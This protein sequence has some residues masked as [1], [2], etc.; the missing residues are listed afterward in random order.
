M[1]QLY[2]DSGQHVGALVACKDQH[3]KHALACDEKTLYFSYPV[4]GPYL[5]EIKVEAYV[6]TKSDEFVIKEVGGASDDG[7]V[8][9]T[10]A[11]NTEGIENCVFAGGFEAVEKTV[12]EVL[13]QALEDSEWSVGTSQ[14]TKKRTIRK[15]DDCNA[16]D[17]LEQCVSTYRAEVELDTLNK[18]I[19]IFEARGQNRGVFFMEGVN[20]QRLEYVRDSYDFFTE[21][22]PIGKDGL[23]LLSDPDD[24]VLILTNYTY[25]HKRVKRIWRDERYTNVNTLREDA[26]A[27][28]AEACQP[29]SSYSTTVK[30]LSKS[31]VEHPDFFAYEVGDT[32]TLISK[33]T[34][35]K[36]QQRIV[37]VDEY[38]DNTDNT[39]ELNTAAKSFAQMQ[40]DEAEAAAETA[41]RLSN[42]YTDD[43][44]GDYTTAE[45]AEEIA[46]AAA[47][48]ID[49]SGYATKDQL[50][51]AMNY[52]YNVA[53]EA[54][55]AAETAAQEYAAT[56]EANAKSAFQEALKAYYTAEMTDTTIQE[57]IDGHEAQEA[58]AYATKAE[59]ATVSAAAEMAQETADAANNKVIGTAETNAAGVALVALPEEFAAVAAGSFRIW[60][61]AHGAA[62]L[63]V[64]EYSTN[65]FTVEGAQITTF[66]WMAVR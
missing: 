34:G 42:A 14:I 65:S 59:V 40:K 36:E 45:E 21:I 3:V 5:H 50:T 51:N 18:V 43:S 23:T 33:K 31:S 57:A 11:M 58:G 55:E 29:L 32:I 30:D 38:E 54:Q 19:N 47:G 66:D 27:K 64:S 2:T 13:T 48:E 15:E 4:T 10:A 8:S 53:Q 39:V 60:L 37:T 41:T 26:V 22:I 16:W 1:L 46:A 56:A 44:L 7:W 25:S 52:A 62:Q 12:A 61:Q 9:V 24:P 63:Y 35:I 20:L 17:V 6:R 49:L 28:L